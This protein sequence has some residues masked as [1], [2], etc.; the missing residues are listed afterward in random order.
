MC[1]KRAEL[2]PT[3]KEL[4]AADADPPAPVLCKGVG[5]GDGGG[6]DASGRAAAAESER[7][8]FECVATGFEMR[9]AFA[10]AQRWRCAGGEAGA[11]SM[12]LA[13]AV[14]GP[15]GDDEGA[16]ARRAARDILCDWGDGTMLPSWLGARTYKDGR[17]WFL[18]KHGADVLFGADPDDEARLH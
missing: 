18:D 13:L 11:A 9:A 16:R 6:E 10:L 5:D 4:L 3:F 8:P 7:K 2:L 14:L 15:Q 17:G 1:L 12:P